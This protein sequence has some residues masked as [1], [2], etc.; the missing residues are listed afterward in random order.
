M[1]DLAVILKD[2]QNIF[3]ERGRAW[4][5]MSSVSVRGRRLRLPGAGKRQDQSRKG[6]KSKGSLRHKR[7][8]SAQPLQDLQP[9]LGLL[10]VWFFGSAVAAQDLRQVL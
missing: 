4:I 5:L 3:V 9:G 8:C 7:N 1:A 6:G 10:F 2:R